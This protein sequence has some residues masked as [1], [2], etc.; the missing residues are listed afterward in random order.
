[1]ISSLRERVR[2]WWLT[3]DLLLVNFGNGPGRV[4]L[5]MLSRTNVADVV[6]NR[7]AVS[8]SSRSPEQKG[9]M[10]VVHARTTA[11]AEK[12]A[13]ELKRRKRH[14]LEPLSEI[15][16]IVHSRPEATSISNQPRLVGGDIALAGVPEGDYRRNGNGAWILRTLFTEP[17]ASPNGG[18]AEPPCTSDAGGGPPSVS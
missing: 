7:C 9:W 14:I 12:I 2:Q 6:C 18:L 15:A 17:S 10:F 11:Q 4:P 5:V 16:C 8:F 3:R 13:T 1:M